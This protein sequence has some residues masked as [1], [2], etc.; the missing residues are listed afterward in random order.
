MLAK[1]VKE[2]TVL[3]LTSLVVFSSAFP[4]AAQEV[5]T[6]GVSGGSVNW[7][8][9]TGNSLIP[10]SANNPGSN[11]IT[12]SSSWSLQPGRTALT[13]YAYFASATAALQHAATVC[14]TGC[15]DI[16]SSALEIG[17]NGGALQS[18]SGTG[19]F[20]AAN[21]S[22]T[23]INT[24]ITGANKNSSRNDVLRFNINLSAL[25]QLPADSYTGTLFL[26][27]Q[28]TP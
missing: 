26:R 21:A 6:V 11:T 22:L 5:I 27:A 2:H 13:F 12:L 4:L 20:G 7:S 10:G 25:P 24:K 8:T 1:V 18:V 9:A 14:T 15:A 3:L 28:A 17:L 16:P 23:L 19:P